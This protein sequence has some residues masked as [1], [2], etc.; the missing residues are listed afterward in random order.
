MFMS[1]IDD[2][3][4]GKKLIGGFVIVLI[5]MAIIAAY[6]YT[7]AQDAAARSKDMYDNNLAAIDQMGLVSAD[8][9]QM[10]AEIY[11]YIYIPAAR[12]TATTT[13]DGIKSNIK[14]NIDIYRKLDLT[15]ED[16]A[17]LE[18]F[19]SNY[20]T[21]LVEYDKTLK[22]A[23][24]ND[25]K[26]VDAALTAGSPLINARTNTVAAYKEIIKLN[27]VGAAELNKESSAA[28]AA[29]YMGILAVAG[30]LI[31]LG[32]ALYMAKT[33]TGPIELVANNLKELSKGHLSVR[34]KLDRKDEIGDMARTMDNYANGQQK[35]VIG[36][37]QMIAQGDLSRD[38]KPQDAQDEV[39]PAS[40]T[41]TPCTHRR[42]QHAL[43]GSRCRPA[44]HPRQCR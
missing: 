23:D 36:T 3:K 39:V 34:L 5:I 25:M 18:T 26:T 16:K 9:Q 19:D 2:M 40:H 6:G 31:G 38:L 22:A 37:M 4:I 10:R 33:I 21:W 32:V 12:T 41:I 15:K 20:A 7:S 1:F 13:I 44:R 28:A 42:I 14:T 8:F 17:A 43:K 29:L 11:R 30:I 24:A 35:W 27:E